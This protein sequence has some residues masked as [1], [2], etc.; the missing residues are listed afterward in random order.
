MHAYTPSALMALLGFIESIRES[1]TLEEQE[2]QA[3][4]EVYLQKAQQRIFSHL[5]DIVLNIA[6]EGD[7]EEDE[8]NDIDDVINPN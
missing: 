5:S 7:E 1:Y 4:A 8:L 6:N 3:E 2:E